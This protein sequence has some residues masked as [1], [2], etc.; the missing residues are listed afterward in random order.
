MASSVAARPANAVPNVVASDY[1]VGE[2]Y[3]A[4]E[5]AA[6]IHARDP[7]VTQLKGVH[8]VYR[9]GYKAI[10]KSLRTPDPTKTPDGHFIEVD[11][12]SKRWLSE[13]ADRA[14]SANTVAKHALEAID[15]DINK[16]LDIAEGRYS[17]EIRSHFAKLAP[18]DRIAAAR[19]AIE[20]FDTDTMAA[21]LSGPAY[22]SGL[23]DDERGVLRNLFMEK[24]AADAISRKRVIEKALSVNDS[25]FNGALVAIGQLLPKGRADEIT[26]RMAE[27]AE[28]RE[29]I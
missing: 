8:D 1:L 10:E 23:S 25:A 28:A 6:A 26:S 14:M 3:K 20:K 21:I 27:A 2:W 11:N 16:R 5:L 19:A 29:A 7:I 13:A 4:P 24:H 15:A 18:N 22:L 12:R 9:E 17:A